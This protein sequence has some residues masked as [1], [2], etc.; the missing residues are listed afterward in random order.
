MRGNT[1]EINNALRGYQVQCLTAKH[2]LSAGRK[3]T[4][5]RMLWAL[6]HDLTQ[7]PTKDSDTQRL[8]RLLDKTISLWGWGF[9]WD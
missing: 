9:D 5:L 2:E 4:G 1:L 7:A 3:D 6:H 8:K